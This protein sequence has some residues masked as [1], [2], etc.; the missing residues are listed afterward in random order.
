MCAAASPSEAGSPEVSDLMKRIPSFNSP[1]L[2]LGKPR[3]RVPLCPA[4]S[5]STIRPGASRSNDETA[6]AETAGWRDE[7]LVT[8][9][10]IRDRR[11]SRATIVAA[12]HG[13]IALPG[14]SAMPIMS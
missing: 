11:T 8:Q 14:V 12:T 5:P 2:E 13:S 3:F 9:S 7:R 1:R 6:A 4:P 10:A